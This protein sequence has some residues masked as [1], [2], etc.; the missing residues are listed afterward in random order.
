MIILDKVKLLTDTYAKFKKYT[1]LVQNI[2]K[3]D[4]HDFQKIIEKNFSQ[5]YKL[6]TDISYNSP[7]L[8]PENIFH[9]WHLSEYILYLIEKITVIILDHRSSVDVMK[10]EANINNMQK[11]ATNIQLVS[12]VLNKKNKNINNS[13]CNYIIDN[14]IWDDNVLNLTNEY[15]NFTKKYPFSVLLYC[16]VIQSSL[17]Y[18]AKHEKNS[19]KTIFNMVDNMKDFVVLN[20][21]TQ[22][23]GKNVLYSNNPR[24]KT[25]G[26]TPRGPSSSL[27]DIFQYI[28]GETNIKKITDLKKLTKA[29]DICIVVFNSVIKNPMEFELWKIID[30]GYAKNLIQPENSGINLQTI[31]RFTTFRFL[32]QNSKYHKWNFK[33]QYYGDIKSELFIILEH[34]GLDLY[35]QLSIYN[36][37]TSNFLNRQK[38]GGKSLKRIIPRS[39]IEHVIKYVENKG[40]L[41]NNT[42]ISEY[43]KM[44][45]NIIIKNMFLPIKF[46]LTSIKENSQELDTA[47]LQHDINIKLTKVCMNLVKTQY[48]NSKNI[49][50]IIDIGK[51]IHSEKLIDTI[52]SIFINQYN[53]YVKN[54]TINNKFPSS[55]LLH[56][57][58]NQLK[59]VSRDFIRH[60][61]SKFIETEIDNSIFDL[62]IE[63]KIDKL[64]MIFSSIISPVV[65][66]LV[67]NEN[68]VY[69]ALIYKNFILNLSII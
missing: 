43:N 1:E 37:E 65:N 66:K 61:H 46:D 3:V 45:E 25:F 14:T 41:Y 12:D 40:I 5:M 24:L 26:L 67:S 63:K 10:S 2:A 23:L 30:W 60:I 39:Q 48:K 55:E 49:K 51:I 27:Q 33:T 35:R 36:Y 54:K 42:R 7:N 62:T 59:L 38:K 21:V 15:T 31:E 22:Q 28:Y 69:Q 18:C 58:L 9:I 32:D 20:G 16:V 17:K 53:V 29:K 44:Q 11:L 34:M 6:S 4:I 68:N 13:I 64:E 19:C 8:I 47:Y 50:T 52:V 56:T 57:L